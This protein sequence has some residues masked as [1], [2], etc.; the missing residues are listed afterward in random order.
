MIEKV[1]RLRFFLLASLLFTAYAATAAFAEKAELEKA[2]KAF[3]DA[4]AIFLKKNMVTT[5]TD[6]KGTLNI[7]TEVEEEIYFPTEKS[8]AYRKYSVFHSFFTEIADLKASTFS[9]TGG[10]L[11]ELKVDHFTTEDNVNANIFYDDLKE[12]NFVFPGVTAGSVAKVNYTEKLKDPHFM[13]P[14]FFVSYMP[15]IQSSYT[16]NCPAN[17][18]L[19]Y[20]LF[21]ND[22]N[23]VAFSKQEKGGV[24]SYR[25]QGQ[26]L[27]SYSQEEG[28]P[29]YASVSPHVLVA[30]TQYIDDGKTTKVIP[31]LD[32][33][34]HWYG[35]FVHDI[36]KTDDPQLTKTVENALKGATSDEEKIKRIYY[37]VQDNIHYVAFEDSMN[38]FVPREAKDICLKRYGDC[39]DMSSI[40]VAMLKIA[41]IKAYHVW[42]GTRS[43]PYR[44]SDMA[45]PNIDNHMICIADA[46]NKRYV[47]DGTGKFTQLGLVTEFI[48]GKEALLMHDDGNCEIYQIPVM[49]KEKTVDADSIT[50]NFNGNNEVRGYI[51]AD[52]SGYNKVKE[53]YEYMYSQPE[54]REEK[55]TGYLQMGNNK[56]KVTDL[57]IDGMNGQDSILKIKGQYVL[58]EYAKAVAGKIYFNPNL[59]K[60]GQFANIDLSN[61]TLPFEIEYKNIKKTTTIINIPDGY[62]ADYVPQNASF[63]GKNGAFSITYQVDGNRVIQHKEIDTDFLVLSVDE[64]KDWNKMI[65]EMDKAYKENIAF[66]KN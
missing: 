41:G 16:I 8:E 7:Q 1:S 58:P 43:L 27:K 5:I 31:D 12:I 3:P 18:S 66:V 46:G 11:K 55:F 40:L 53:S 65:L 38:G 57:H 28:A 64:L 37:W 59:E 35:S 32:G 36:N 61:R 49:P 54:K 25:W 60:E 34:C 4:D 62:K 19:N 26:N 6:I 42:I 63:K 51:E 48:Q 14:F 24:V 45:S 39:K 52:L 9:N 29:S 56:C 47:L 13:S 22:S 15:V 2:R 17:V 30:I 50:V 44:Y 21:N 23:Q 33:L 20:R 10:K